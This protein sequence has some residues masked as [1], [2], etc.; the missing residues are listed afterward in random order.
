MQ[1]AKARYEILVTAV[2]WRMESR[3]AVGVAKPVDHELPRTA[4]RDGVHVGNPLEKKPYSP[5]YESIQDDEVAAFRQ[6]LAAASATSLAT[7][8]ATGKSR[9]GPHSYTLLT[10][11]EDTEMREPAA[12]P[13]LSNTQYG[14]LS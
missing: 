5:R 10:G 2:Y 6:A 1:T 4:A 13:G 9:S 11:F 8:D 14:A 12:A 7:V 3:S